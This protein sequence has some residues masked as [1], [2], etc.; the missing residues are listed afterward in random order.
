MLN[1][2]KWQDFSP[3]SAEK[4]KYEAAK[5]LNL[6]GFREED[7]YAWERLDAFKKR[8]AEYSDQAK[9]TWRLAQ[10]TK[11]GLMGDVYENVTGIVQGKWVRHTADLNGE[12]RKRVMN[13]TEISPDVDWAFIG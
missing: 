11:S 10:D 3:K 13:L 6:T 7:E 5:Y 2:T 8:S 12:P 4:S 1:I 9:G